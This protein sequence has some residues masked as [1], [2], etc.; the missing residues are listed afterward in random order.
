V[1]APDYAGPLVGW[2]G[3]LVVSLEEAFR[4]CSP[5][6]PTVWLPR[7]ATVADC[8]AE[9]GLA[10]LPAPAEHP[11]PEERCRCGI[12]ASDSPVAAASF[13]RSP[14]LSRR[15]PGLSWRQPRVQA[16]VFGRVS[17]WGR[18]VECDRGWRGERAYPALLYVPVLAGDAHRFVPQ[19][20]TPSLP[21]E[22]VAAALAAYGVPVEL[23]SCE[24][25][26]QAASELEAAEQPQ[27]R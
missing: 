7:R 4:L 16:P 13:I 6:Y 18:I 25:L 10:G 9:Q 5:V 27:D 21:P 19:P 2:R 22:A 17:L 1:V 12:Y 23:L 3:W 8:L 14:R 11:A 20:D 24:T 26:E 15:S